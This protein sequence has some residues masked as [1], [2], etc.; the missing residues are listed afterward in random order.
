MLALDPHGQDIIGSAF[1]GGFQSMRDEP[2]SPRYYLLFTLGPKLMGRS[3]RTQSYKHNFRYNYMKHRFKHSVQPK[4][5]DQNVK[6]ELGITFAANF[7][8][9][10]AVNDLS[11]MTVEFFE[12]PLIKKLNRRI[13]YNSVYYKCLISHW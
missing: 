13:G 11:S 8:M 4:C 1:V 12:V 10:F 9:A 5:F 3:A 7:F 6:Y 2:S